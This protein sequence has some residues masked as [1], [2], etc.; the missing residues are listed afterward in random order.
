[1]QVFIAKMVYLFQ[2]TQTPQ[3]QILLPN[4]PEIMDPNTQCFAEYSEG[5]EALEKLSID[6]VNALFPEM[7]KAR[8]DQA[9]SSLI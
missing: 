4:L 5:G 1:M 6:V 9:L 7:F 8:S 2:G 3:I